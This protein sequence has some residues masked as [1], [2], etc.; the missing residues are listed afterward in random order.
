MK[1]LKIHNG[2]I[3]VGRGRKLQTITGPAKVAQD[4][5]QWLLNDAGFNRFHLE[6]GSNLDYFVGQ[7]LTP[8]LIQDIDQAVRK[9]LN[10]YTQKQLEDLKLRI[11]ERGNPIIAINMSD[12]S[13]IVRRWTAVN[14]RAEFSTIF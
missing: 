8:Q 6:L 1:D 13:S 7:P 10:G 3:V 9:A 11:A 2:D 12:P 4:V 14:I 5:R